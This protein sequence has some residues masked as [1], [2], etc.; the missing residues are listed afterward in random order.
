MA[1][2][3]TSLF[4][5]HTQGPNKQLGD[6]T[7][8]QGRLFRSNAHLQPLI[9]ERTGRNKVGGPGGQG[10]P[11][12]GLCHRLLHFRESC[13]ETPTST[14]TAR[15]L[16]MPVDFIK[17]DPR[18]GFE[19]PSGRFIDPGGTAQMTRIMISHLHGHFMF[20]LD[21]PFLDEPVY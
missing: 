15:V 11:H 7:H 19:D 2:A 1:P 20:V 3:D 4:V 18:D 8:D 13:L 14:A 16:M 9:T 17:F 5:I 10:I 21:L 6:I 12:P